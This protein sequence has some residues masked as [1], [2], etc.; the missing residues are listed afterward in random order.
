MVLGPHHFLI[1]EL[2]LL[3]VSFFLG[4]SL[5]TETANLSQCPPQ[6]PSSCSWQQ[7]K[8]MELTQEGEGG[9]QI[10]TQGSAQV[11]VK[12]RADK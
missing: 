1:T 10:V 5:S 8:S 2:Q 4:V 9:G 6:L 3:K 12:L 7:Q 11:R